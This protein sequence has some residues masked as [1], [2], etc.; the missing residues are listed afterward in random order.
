VKL[1]KGKRLKSVASSETQPCPRGLV[2]FSVGRASISFGRQKK[3][4]GRW[5]P[6]VCYSLS[7]YVAAGTEDRSTPPRKGGPGFAHVTCLGC[8]RNGFKRPV[9]KHGPRSLTCLRVFGWQTHMRN[10]SER[11]G[12]LSWKAPTP[13]PEL[14]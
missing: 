13:G 3:G 1:L 14:L 4:R 9:L 2:Y 12:L 10:E 8:W 11:L 6:R 7:P 5:H